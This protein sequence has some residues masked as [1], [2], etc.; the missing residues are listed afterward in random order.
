MTIIIEAENHYFCFIFYKMASLYYSYHDNREQQYPPYDSSPYHSLQNQV[1]NATPATA[2]GQ[3]QGPSP[4]FLKRILI[5]DDDPDITLALKTVLEDN[6]YTVCIFNDPID[7]VS[8]F[9]QAGMY[10][11][12]IIDLVMPNMDGF[13][14]Y[15]KVKKIDNKV[16]ACFITAYDVHSEALREI[17]P[18]FEIDCFMKK[19]IENE[20]LLT[21][22]MS[23][24]TI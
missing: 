16:K 17:Y 3:T 21:K 2:K 7:A 13:E 14:F 6:G 5:V 11:L 10:D 15:E 24:T 20:D 19:P 23:S 18:D 9:K 22:V 8:N 1:T 12:L 4:A